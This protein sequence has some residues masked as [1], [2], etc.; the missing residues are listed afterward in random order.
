MSG[1]R[2][3]QKPENSTAAN[4]QVGLNHAVLET[5]L[6]TN[7]IPI[8]YGTVVRMICTRRTTYEH[9]ANNYPWRLSG[10]RG[11]IHRAAICD[12]RQIRTGRDPHFENP[13]Y[14]GGRPLLKISF[15]SGK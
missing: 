6:F 15:S 10:D 7:R 8:P 13:G 9:F 3:L 14:S 11:S 12:T 4:L 1:Y 5:P 2:L